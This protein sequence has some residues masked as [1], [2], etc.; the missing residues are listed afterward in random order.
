MLYLLLVLFCTV[1]HLLTC[2]E[3]N[4]G[5]AHELNPL[6]IDLMS[7]PVSTS[8]PLRLAWILAALLVLGFLTRFRPVLIKKCLRALVVVYGLVIIYHGTV[9]YRILQT[10]LQVNL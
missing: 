8:L 10:V 1:D 7:L 5:L 4:T 9:I 2:W 6:L 3:I